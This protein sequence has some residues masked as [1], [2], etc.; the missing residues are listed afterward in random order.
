[1]PAWWSKEHE[2]VLQALKKAKS[3]NE[4]S[5]ANHFELPLI[6]SKP[7]KQRFEKIKKSNPQKKTRFTH[8][9]DLTIVKLYNEHGSKWDLIAQSLPNRTGV[10]IK[11]RFYSNIKKNG[12]LDD[13]L[14]ELERSDG[15]VFSSQSSSPKK[16]K[17]EAVKVADDFA[18]IHMENL[19]EE[20]SNT[21]LN[22]TAGPSATTDDTV[23]SP[24]FFLNTLPDDFH[25]FEESFKLPESA[26]ALA[27]PRLY[28]KPFDKQKDFKE[29]QST[30]NSEDRQVHEEAPEK[31]LGE[32]VIEITGDKFHKM[33]AREKMELIRK[34]LFSVQFL[35]EDTK[36]MM[37]KMSSN[38]QFS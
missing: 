15:Q 6:Y 14:E 35:F 2:E 26:S 37:A 25:L 17:K 18:Q 11:N 12:L 4:P 32:P 30:N 33:D 3:S 34:K 36:S 22:I 21:N 13:L 9:E 29:Y 38:Y 1:V 8:Q 7:L 27:N 10:M 16:T 31:K 19:N 23:K 5:I 24:C 28:G 20:K